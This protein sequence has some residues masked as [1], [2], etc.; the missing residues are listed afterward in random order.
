MLAWSLGPA[1]FLVA[2]SDLRP[3][4]PCNE[5]MKYADDGYIIVPGNQ[6]VTRSDEPAHVAAW[7]NVNNL[8]LNHL[9]TMEIVFTKPKTRVT[10]AIAEPLQDIQRVTNIKAL[11]IHLNEK[12]SM[13]PH[14]NATLSS[15]NQSMYALRVLRTH[16]MSKTDIW[17]TFQAIVISKLLYAAPAW[18]GFANLS[19]IGRLDAFLRRARRQQFCAPTIATVSE[20][21][22]QLDD[23]LFRNVTKNPDH[24]LF[25]LLPPKISHTH[26]TRRR[27]H[28]HILPCKS[29]S[30][31]DLNFF[32]RLL[33]KKD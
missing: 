5:I 7:A 1:A 31:A 24:V 28:N 15:C 19:E 4:H 16:G 27:R 9:K 8:K 11:G 14:I 29:A 6:A 26:N 2:A 23:T 20:L 17:T 30:L 22:A 32:C 3:V 33:Y 13:L 12:L 18:W 21:C 25:P 10:A